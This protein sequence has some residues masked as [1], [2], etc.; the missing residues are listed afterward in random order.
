[1]ITTYFSARGVVF[2]GENV[3]PHEIIKDYIAE[4][5]A[6]PL[7]IELLERLN[8]FHENV[9]FTD[10]ISRE[11]IDISSSIVNGIVIYPIN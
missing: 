2:L 7:N 11:T 5:D 6:T 1:M 3:L 9:T 4:S 10:I 8:R